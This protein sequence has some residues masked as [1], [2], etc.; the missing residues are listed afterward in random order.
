MVSS[1]QS[2]HF[3][4][5]GWEETTF[6]LCQL[7]VPSQP[8]YQHVSSLLR[9]RGLGG[10][11]TSALVVHWRELPSPRTARHSVGTGITDSVGPS[12]CFSQLPAAAVPLGATDNG[13]RGYLKG[14]LYL[15][16]SSIQVAAGW[17]L[18]PCGPFPSRGRK[19]GGVGVGSSSFSLS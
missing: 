11:E 15:P 14:G 3:L 19:G 8:E 1:S 9:G 2:P 16:H 18:P 12:C 17:S 7:L 4:P 5:S 6:L 13:S 10:P